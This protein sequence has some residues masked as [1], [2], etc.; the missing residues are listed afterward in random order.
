MQLPSY[1]SPR[2][3]MELD[4]AT[5]ATFER[6]YAEAVAH[7]AGTE[8]DYNLSAP[9]WQFLCYLSDTKGILMH[10]SGNPSISQ[11][12]PRQSNDITEFGNRRAVYAAS[13]G[14][15]A[16]YFAIVDRDRHVTSLM[17]ACFR[18]LQEGDNWS[19]CYYFFS[20]NGD[21]LPHRPWR[22]GTVYLLPSA[23]FEKQPPVQ[24][25]GTM[26]EI[27]QWAGPVAVKPLAKLTVN[28]E[29]FPFLAQIYP[30]DPEVVVERAKQNPD[31]FPWLH[32]TL[33][34]EATA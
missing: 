28:P 7:G 17:N 34:D 29:D 23:T 27:A 1:Y 8:I 32:D 24:S 2:P 16:M 26:L 19:D 11:F 20:V 21:A 30:H 3:A 31:G 14:I 4:A 15:W 18:V 33:T 12:E 22:K 25:R 9:K 6:L 5:T 13:D 10:G